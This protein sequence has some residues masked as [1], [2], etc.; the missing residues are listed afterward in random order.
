[1]IWYAVTARFPAYVRA[2]R[3][4]AEL[5]AEWDDRGIDGVYRFLNKFWSLVMDNKDKTV[6]PTK[7]MVKLR[8]RMVH[9]ITQRLE[10]FSLNTVI[11]GFMEYNNKLIELAKRQDGLD[12][13][14][15]ETA[16]TL[17]APFAPI[18]QRS[19]GSSSVTARPS[20][21]TAGRM[22]MRKP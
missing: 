14:T 15:L 22:L 2:F 7:E 8:H 9:T 16:V 20:S 12:K 3:G 18:S 10:S 4:T 21:D 1:M 6:E 13:E 11:S 5:D 19:S 17:I